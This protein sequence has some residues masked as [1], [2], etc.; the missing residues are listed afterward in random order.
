MAG[1][2]RV[3]EQEFA[4]MR[5]GFLAYNNNWQMIVQSMRREVVRSEDIPQ[6]IKDLWQRNTD[7]QLRRRVRDAVSS[8]L[9]V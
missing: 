5:A 3:H 6:R 7:R 4:L 9:E 1:H 2:T 8:R